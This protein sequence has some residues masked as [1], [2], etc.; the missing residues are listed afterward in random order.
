MSQ[1]LK[2]IFLMCLSAGLWS[3]DAAAG[4]FAPAAGEPNSIAIA[5]PKDPNDHSVF[6]GW[7]T[8]VSV[9]RGLQKIDAPSFGYASH[10][11]PEGALG[12]A[13]GQTVEGVVSLG[14]GGT[15]VLMFDPPIANGPGWDFAVFE[16]GFVVNS[17]NQMFLE[18]AFVEVSSDG[19]HY[20]RF[21]AVSLTKAD[22]PN[23]QVPN[24]G[25][26]DTTN[27]HNFAGKYQRG[28]GTPFDLEEIRDVN[29]L[30]DAGRI[31]YIRIIDVVGSID[32]AWA[33]YDSLG[34]KIN[35]PWPTP[36]ST[37]G[38][39]LDAVGV[40]HAKTLSA[41]F[42]NDGVVNY[43]DFIIFSALFL[44]PFPEGGLNTDDLSMWTQQWL[45]T[46]TWRQGQ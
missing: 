38:F 30:V 34:N 46:E 11:R 32:D 28:Y 45:E 1:H 21:G 20:E 41:D 39:D 4:P 27:I 35:D 33:S 5:M 8:G 44:S 9:V 22:D 10:G 31:T 24:L 43:E 15:A 42:N 26:I 25:A 40:M 14:D 18:L 2:P 17:P 13:Q 36:F 23:D 19:V 3:L 12:P 29:D 6:V 16:N 7:A 37:G